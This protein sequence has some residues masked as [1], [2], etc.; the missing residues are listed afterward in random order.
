MKWVAFSIPDGRYI[1]V[2]HKKYVVLN[3]GD[4]LFVSDEHVMN[5]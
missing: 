5:D 2:Y 1:I 3:N 4:D